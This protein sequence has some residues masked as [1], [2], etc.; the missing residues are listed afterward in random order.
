M[1]KVSITLKDFYNSDTDF[2]GYVDRYCRT[3]K[4]MVDEAL[5][6]EIVRMVYL[7]YRETL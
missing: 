3:Y 2:R 5:T 4:I 1:S 6:H 7:H